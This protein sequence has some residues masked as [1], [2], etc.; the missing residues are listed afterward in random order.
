M[1]IKNT[2]KEV[3]CFH[4]VC[5]EALERALKQ[6]NLDK[7]Y[8]VQHHRY[9]GTIEMD[10][11][12]ASKETN[13]ILCVVE[14]K[15]TIAAVNSTR[16]QYQAM[17]Y[18]QS[19]RDNEL[20]S[21]Y[22]LLTNLES[23]CL[24]KFDKNRPNV[25]EQ[26]IEPGFSLNHKFADVSKAEFMTDLTKQYANFIS[27]VKN[28]SGKYMLSF[29][30][31]A[32]E[33]HDKLDKDIEWKK[34]LVALFYEYIRG[35]FTKINRNELRTISQLSN[36][37]DLICREGLK[38]NFKDIF[39]LPELA[40]KQRN[41]ET[42]RTLLQQ[43][44]DL[45]KT[46][47][48]ADELASV[49]H[50]VVS[51]EHKHEGEVPT[52]TDL[53]TLMLW[54]VKCITG[55]L[56]ADEKIMDP[57][58][59]SGSLLCAAVNVYEHIQPSQLIA[60]DINS[61]L[62]QLLSLRI[63]LKFASTI[64]KENTAQITSFNIADLPTTEFEH[65]KAI[66]M[67]PPYLAA[68]GVN[69]VSRKAELYRRIRLLKGCDP[70]TTSG[71]M[72][73]EG[74]FVELVST[75][76]KEGTVIAAI[77]PN[78]HFTTKGDASRA[79][80]K[81]LLND[82]GLQLIF[83][84]PQERLFEGVTQ[85]TSIV[86]GVKGTH[87]N[88]VRYLYSNEIVFEIDASTISEI[89]KL[90]LSIEELTNINSQF[91]GCILPREKLE[92]MIDSGWQIGN[93]SKKDAQ[94]FIQANIATSRLLTTL[95]DSEFKDYLRG[96]IGNDGCTGL[97]YM[98][99]NNPFLKEAYSQLKGHLLPGLS[100][101]KFNSVNIGEG[102]SLFFNVEGMTDRQIRKVVDL[103]FGEGHG[104][105]KKQRRDNKTQEKYVAT[106]KKESNHVSPAH[107]VMLPRSIRSHGRVFVSDRPTFVSSN[108][109]VIEADESRAKILAS[110]FSTIFYQLECEAYG[111]N[112]AGAR[113][114]EEKDY[115]PLHVPVT[116]EL[117]EE[118]KQR[119]AST[120]I[121]EFINLRSPQVRNVDRV[122]AEILFGE[123]ADE[124]I[125]EALTLVPILVA[126]REK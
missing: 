60:N 113:K 11:V 67:N 25:Y 55:E 30:Q 6:L 92:Q 57:A 120:P 123:N 88:D 80:R 21:R 100:N 119:I 99:A 15:R 18:V 26:I 95:S 47:V 84:Y 64:E 87:A 32:D 98:K 27:I 72:P 106:L 112:R 46:Y 48:D 77:L 96:K 82:F 12:I 20:E 66:V 8:E 86:I 1:W 62:L 122:W 50:K 65:V 115:N 58:S 114:L 116:S 31:F 23:S 42:S 9:V 17:S 124:L 2:D 40:S 102:E 73:L 78:T 83:N 43:L 28:D 3:E 109:F 39:T 91:E 59:G 13:K 79:I 69:C 101:A 54:L 97:L 49:M 45:G 90:N 29:K 10:L 89:L 41:V 22:Y 61:R 121:N 36:K 94:N 104:K 52:D 63:G 71:Q 7:D 85:N 4:P 93:M 56:K 53:A 19:L 51:E 111:N 108:F 125:E 35:S 33:I 24:F 110:W 117:S 103:Y 126:D 118:E 37:V 81:M 74:P 107:C 76:A 16:Y 105:K 68:T 70:T 5:K 14:V 44:F 38:V 75:L 34:A